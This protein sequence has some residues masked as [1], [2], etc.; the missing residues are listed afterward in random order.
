MGVGR[1]LAGEREGKMVKQHCVHCENV[2]VLYTTYASER[3]RNK[4]EKEIS[5]TLW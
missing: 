1:G 4:E 2:I 3:G 5:W